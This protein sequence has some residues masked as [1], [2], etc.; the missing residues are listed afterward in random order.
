MGSKRTVHSGGS[1]KKFN[2]FRPVNEENL[3]GCVIGITKRPGKSFGREMKKKKRSK[4]KASRY[5]NLIA[6]VIIRT[7]S[8][9]F[10]NA[11]LQ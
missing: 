8:G 2:Y 5:T 6:S 11:R 3:A 7:R 10:L 4:N 1:D 9:T